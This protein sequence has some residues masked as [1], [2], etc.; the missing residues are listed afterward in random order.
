MA[1]LGSSIFNRKAA[2]KLRSPDDLDKYIRVTN[3]SVWVVLAAC[4]L[5]LAGLM[6]WGF[7][8][9][10]A[11]TVEDAGVYID[12]KVVCFVDTE[13]ASKIRVGNTAVVDGE[14]M[15]VESIASVP[16]SL[17]ESTDFLKSDYLAH[18]LFEGDWNY[19]V[20]LKGDGDYD[21]QSSVPMRVVITTE[22]IAP[23]SLIV[24]GG[25]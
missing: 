2:E 3:P 13:S 20:T 25:N 4:I 12:G 1:D 14:S 6:V 19:L 22:R 15:E 24:G 5:L 21:F 17:A 11:T 8:G 9:T 16:M 10:V 18:S 23:I 7:L